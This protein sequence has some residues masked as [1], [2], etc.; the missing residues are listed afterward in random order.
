MSEAGPWS[1]GMMCCEDSTIVA[2]YFEDG[3][4]RTYIAKKC[5]W[6]LDNEKARN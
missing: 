5:G 4:R 6:S 1:E 3:G 2:K